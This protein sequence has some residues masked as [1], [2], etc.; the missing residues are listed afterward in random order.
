MSIKNGQDDIPNPVRPVRP[1]FSRSEKLTLH[2]TMQTG[3]Q[4]VHSEVRE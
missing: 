4:V 1:I 2:V 3:E